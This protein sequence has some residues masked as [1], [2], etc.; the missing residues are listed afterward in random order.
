[1]IGLTVGWSSCQTPFG[2]HIFVSVSIPQIFRQ[3]QGLLLDLQAGVLVG[4]VRERRDEIDG[5]FLFYLIERFE[6]GADRRVAQV[7]QGLR[8]GIALLVGSPH[9]VEM[10]P[11]E[12]PDLLIRVFL[13]DFL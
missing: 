11:S 13:G 5:L 7:V 10:L 1:M 6:A 8:P 2:L 9:R 3:V 12:I 4:H